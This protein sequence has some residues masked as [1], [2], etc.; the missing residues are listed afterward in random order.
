MTYLTREEL[1]RY[2]R[3]DDDNA[4]DTLVDLEDSAEAYLKTAGVNIDSVDESRFKLAVCA[5]TLHWFD[6]PTGGE[7]PA[8]LRQLINQLKFTPTTEEES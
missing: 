5:L 4:A 7:L 3:V 1:M 6:N 2:C 8:G